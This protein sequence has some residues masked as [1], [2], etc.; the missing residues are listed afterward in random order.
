M[1]SIKNQKSEIISDIEVLQLSQS[2]EIFNKASNMF[3]QK[4]RDL[5][6]EFIKYFENEWLTKRNMWFEGVKIL[7]PSTNNALE[8]FNR[9]IKDEGTLRE[10]LPISRFRIVALETVQKWS[11]EYA[12]NLKEFKST[13]TITLDLWTQGYQWAKK[14]KKVFTDENEDSIE[15][16]LAAGDRINLSKSEIDMVKSMNWNSFQQFKENAFSIYFVIM[17]KEHSLW[18]KGTCTCPSFFKKFMCKHVVG[19]AIRLKY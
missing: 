2:R 3:I 5:Q 6:P 8:S 12:I 10:R 17:P 11:K 15:Y 4:W 16:S 14:K 13:A 19:L 1:V 7:T 18:T 9:V